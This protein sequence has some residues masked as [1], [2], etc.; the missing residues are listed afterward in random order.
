VGPDGVEVAKQQDRSL[1][2][3]SG[4]SRRT[5]AEAKLV[6]IT[7][8]LL[9]MPLDTGTKGDTPSGSKLLGGVN[10]CRIFTWAFQTNK[11][12]KMLEEPG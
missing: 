5:G 4:G 9:P 6:D 1:A 7:E 10:C 8:T 3:A 11:L 12:F 2:S